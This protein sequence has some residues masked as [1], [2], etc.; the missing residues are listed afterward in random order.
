MSKKE[1]FKMWMSKIPRIYTR[2]YIFA[3]KKK[4]KSVQESRE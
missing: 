1:R 2:K 4:G 3:R